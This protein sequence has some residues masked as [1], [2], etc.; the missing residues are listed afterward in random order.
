[1]VG[2][3]RVVVVGTV[4][5]ARF[6]IDFEGTTAGLADGLGVSWERRIRVSKTFGGRSWVN[7]GAV[8]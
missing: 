7:E 4:E 2:R 1:M 3:S 8:Y 5:G 6:G